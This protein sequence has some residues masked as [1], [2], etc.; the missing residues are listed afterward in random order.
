MAV[1]RQLAESTDELQTTSSSHVPVLLTVIAVVLIVAAL[2]LAQVLLIPLVLAALAGCGLEPLHR[3]LVRRGVPRRLSA[4]AILIALV[5]GLG[6]GAWALQAQAA[7]FVNQLPILTQRLRDAVRDGRGALGS[8]M[9]PMQQAADELKR[10]A[11]ESA[12]PPAKGVTRVQVETP[13]RLSDLLWRG[14][15][16]ALELLAQAMIVLF[17]VYY[18]L[19]SGDRYKEKLVKLSGPSAFREHLTLEILNRITEQVERFL[20]ARVI[21]STIVAV[22]TTLALAALGISQPV[23][24]GLVAGVL[25][26]VPYLGPIAAVCAITLASLVQFGNIKMAGAAGAASALIA[27]LEGFAIT[28]WIMGRAGRMNAGVVFVSLMFWGWIWGVW[29]LLFAVPI[30]MAVKAVCD[31]VDAF[32]SFGELLSE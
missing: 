29:G 27:L 31:H 11:D 19:A 25:N 2:W 30:M 5:I 17:L 15:M 22:T 4:A 28:P 16:G 21:I 13:V 10:A 20:V 23:M 6:A 12:P 26:N 3:S 32:E 14:T 1:R 9:Q 24:W 7:T 18:L 8:T